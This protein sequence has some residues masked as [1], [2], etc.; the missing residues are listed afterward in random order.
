MTTAMAAG[1]DLATLAKVRF[2]YPTSSAG[3]GMAAR[4]LLAEPA[5]PTELD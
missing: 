4:A 2:A 3:I 5:R 1:V